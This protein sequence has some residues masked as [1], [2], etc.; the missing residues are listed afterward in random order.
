MEADFIS[1]FLL[2]KGGIE[3]IFYMYVAIIVHYDS[4]VTHFLPIKT[5][6]QYLLHPAGSNKCCIGI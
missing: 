3:I 5:P 4:Q 6:L 2:N 1:L